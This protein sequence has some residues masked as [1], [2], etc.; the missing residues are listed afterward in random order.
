MV[1]RRAEAVLKVTAITVAAVSLMGAATVSSCGRRRPRAVAYPEV[2]RQELKE[3]QVRVL[4]F[5]TRTPVLVTLDKGGTAEV[6]EGGAVSRMQLEPVADMGVSPVT[7]GIQLGSRAV[8]CSR[9]RIV[10]AEGSG[11]CVEG[12]TYRGSLHLVRQGD[13]ALLGINEVGLEEYVA[14]VVGAEMP[15]RWPLEALKAQ[16]IAART[17][18][19]Y[20]AR[21]RAEGLFSLYADTRDQM[22]RGLSSETVRAAEAAEATRGVFALYSGRLFP[23]FYHSTCGGQTEP[24]E[25]A[26]SVP[27][28]PPLG[29][30]SCRFCTQSRHYR[31][32]AEVDASEV[33]RAALEQGYRLGDVQA[34][35]SMPVESEREWR[36]VRVVRVDGSSVSLP[37]EVFRNALGSGV[38]RSVM[39][40][41]HRSGERLV[42]EGRGWGHLAGMCQ[43]GARGMALEGYGA[44]EIMGHYFPGVELVK[45]Y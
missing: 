30:V 6:I 21:Q 41:A 37:A 5:E 27:A 36:R 15:A 7:F 25:R 14:S 13:D 20:K 44:N 33:S 22:Y 2:K 35:E 23:T 38:I 24:A 42:F 31:W 4:L 28:L 32:T 18:A 43:W 19:L 1:L 34:I 10:P 45:A 12:G 9:L 3:V 40:E 26:L 17:Y 16:A 11:V 8:A 39:F 29:G